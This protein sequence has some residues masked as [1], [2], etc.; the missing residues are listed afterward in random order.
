MSLLSETATNFVQASRIVQ[1]PL[2]RARE[3]QAESV[4]ALEVGAQSAAFDSVDVGNGGIE[5]AGAASFGNGVQVSG[6]VGLTGDLSAGGNVVATG[7]VGGANVQVTNTLLTGTNGISSSGNPLTLVTNTLV[8]TGASLLQPATGA[9]SGMRLLVT[10][11]G[12]PYKVVLET[13]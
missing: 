1:A 11:N 4:T 7:N 5:C 9:D 13:V 10:I 8:F 12:T 3:V 2:V 6:S